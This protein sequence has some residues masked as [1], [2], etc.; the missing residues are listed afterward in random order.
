MVEIRVESYWHPWLDLAHVS[1]VPQRQTIRKKVLAFRIWIFYCET[2]STCFT[3]QCIH[4]RGPE[5]RGRTKENSDGN[6][7]CQKDKDWTDRTI[8]I[9]VWCLHW[10]LPVLLLWFWLGLELWLQIFLWKLCFS[11]WYIFDVFNNDYLFWTQMII[12]WVNFFS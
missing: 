7:S 9:P 4:A 1:S 3:V 6:C 10:Q 8:L 12:I 11:L 5:G 2:Y